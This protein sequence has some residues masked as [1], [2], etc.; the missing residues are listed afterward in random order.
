MKL[1][2]FDLDLNI[3]HARA[4]AFLYP[5]PIV[6]SGAFLG[7]DAETIRHDFEKLGD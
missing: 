1:S 2:S 7:F 4:K 5:R 6:V 3:R